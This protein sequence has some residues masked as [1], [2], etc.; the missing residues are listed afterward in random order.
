LVRD[1][2]NRTVGNYESKRRGKVI[3]WGGE[4]KRKFE[5]AGIIDSGRGGRRE[6]HALC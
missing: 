5:N 3:A 1:T 4:E 2:Q 6:F